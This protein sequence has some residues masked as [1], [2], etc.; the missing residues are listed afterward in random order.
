M[1]NA[2][3][4]ANDVLYG[5]WRRGYEIPVPLVMQLGERIE[6][7]IKAAYEA[8]YEQARRKNPNAVWDPD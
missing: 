7:A 5:D 8:G 6:K 4:M 2:K 1:L 3:E